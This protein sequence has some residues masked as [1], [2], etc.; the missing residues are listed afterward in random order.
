MA[1]VA[2]AEEICEIIEKE[3]RR[4][5]TGPTEIRLQLLERL[6]P[7]D[8]QYDP[9]ANFLMSVLQTLQIRETL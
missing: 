6:F 8:V 9:S 7:A 1:D 5:H 2:Y 3:R 4:A